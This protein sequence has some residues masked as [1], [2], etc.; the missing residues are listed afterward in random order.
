VLL[1]EWI[2][3]EFMPFIDYKDYEYKPWKPMPK[4][5]CNNPEHNPPSHI[6]LQPG[7]HTYQCPGCGEKV[8]FVV[9]RLIIIGLPLSI[10]ALFLI[11]IVRKISRMIS[12]IKTSGGIEDLGFIL[13]ILVY[14]GIVAGVMVIA[15]FVAVMI[16]GPIFGSAMLAAILTIAVEVF[17]AVNYNQQM[18]R[19]RRNGVRTPLK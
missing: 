11:W 8:T 3:G 2:I 19:A 13:G 7:E 15:I 1:F 4:P 12:G 6:V 5:P 16:N 14:S 9:R 18:R 10:P 17:Y